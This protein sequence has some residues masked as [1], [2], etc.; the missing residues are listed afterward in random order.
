MSKGCKFRSE[1]KS[2]AFTW[3]YELGKISKLER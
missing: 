2:K 3:G 1:F